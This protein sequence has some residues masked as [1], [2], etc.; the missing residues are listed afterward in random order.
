MQH[1]GAEH[2][3]LHRWVDGHMGGWAGETGAQ[4]G[5][6]EAK[7]PKLA[8]YSLPASELAQES[9]NLC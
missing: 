5:R 9:G 3:L 4:W 8:S 1:V 6:S 7:L 2:A